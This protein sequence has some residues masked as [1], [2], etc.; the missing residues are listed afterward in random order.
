MPT[1]TGMFPSRLHRNYTR[2]ANLLGID[3]YRVANTRKPLGI[4]AT[5]AP[6]GQPTVRQQM[7][8]IASAI[9]QAMR[10]PPVHED[11]HQKVADWGWQAES[12]RE[13]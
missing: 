5:K 4:A 10:A 9:S 11:V 13:V 6:T 12:S 2:S 3:P 7:S 1:K 8:K